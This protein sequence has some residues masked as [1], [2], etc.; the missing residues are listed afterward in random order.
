MWMST[1]RAPGAPG[2]PGPPWAAG[3]AGLPGPS[4]PSRLPE[5]QVTILVRTGPCGLS[6]DTLTP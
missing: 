1:G 3:A 5:P 6:P 2:L 4:R